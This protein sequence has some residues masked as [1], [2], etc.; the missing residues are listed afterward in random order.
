MAASDMRLWAMSECLTSDAPAWALQTSD[1]QK[2]PQGDV[3]LLPGAPQTSD[4]QKLPQGD[5]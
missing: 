1:I 3:S 2:L 5:V 4:I